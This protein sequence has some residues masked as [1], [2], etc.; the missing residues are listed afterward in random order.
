MV[1]PPKFVINTI[2]RSTTT[3]PPE[4]ST[5]KMIINV[6]KKSEKA[7]S[8]VSQ[9]QLIKKQ[10]SH[11]KETFGSLSLGDIEAK[12]ADKAQTPLVSK[13]SDELSSFLVGALIMS[14][15]GC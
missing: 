14:Y 1:K 7:I 5:P 11:K 2:R 12:S 15:Y 13:N 9:E 10:E 3:L 6:S 4:K 8:E